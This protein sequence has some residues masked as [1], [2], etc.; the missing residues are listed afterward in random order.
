[1]R[2]IRD[3]KNEMPADFIETLNEWSLESIALIALD[4]RLNLLKGNN[5]EAQRLYELVKEVFTAT[6]EFDI[7]PS[8]WRYYKT[9][10]FKRAMKSFDDTTR[11][12]Y[13]YVEKAVEKYKTTESEDEGGVLEKLLKID[14]NVAVIMSM[15]MLGAGIDTVSIDVIILSTAITSF[16]SD[17]LQRG[18]DSLFSCEKSRKARNSS[19][20]NPQCVAN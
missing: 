7:Q 16:F 10:A 12:I 17:I 11:I 5:P 14:K 18:C 9:P 2:A 4:T 6:Y 8:I 3:E 15:D 19:K 1:M 13:K 20:G